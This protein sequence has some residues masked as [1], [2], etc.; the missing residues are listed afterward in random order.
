VT[1]FTPRRRS[2]LVEFPRSNS[3][4]GEQVLNTLRGELLATPLSLRIRDDRREPIGRQRLHESCDDGIDLARA[5]DHERNILQVGR[6]RTRCVDRGAQGRVAPGSA[7]GARQAPWRRADGYE[8]VLFGRFHPTGRD[9]YEAA[10][11]LH[12]GLRALALEALG[13]GP[14]D[15]VLSVLPINRVV[16]PADK[17]SGVEVELTVI[18]SPTRSGQA[19]DPAEARQSIAALESRLRAM[20]LRKA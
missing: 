9:D 1:W 10:R 4:A 17:Q 2:C 8:L 13:P 20:G 7:Q 16:V 3:H 15:L 5:A 6:R 11:T 19:P 18:G 14:P 12:E